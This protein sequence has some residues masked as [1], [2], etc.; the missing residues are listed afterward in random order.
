VNVTVEHLAPCRKL[1]R[2][3]VDAQE[4]NSAFEQSTKDFQREARLPGFRPGKAPREMVAKTYAKEIAEE[5][6]RKLISDSYRKALESEKLVVIGYPDIEE[7]QFARGQP[8]QFAATVETAPEFELPEYKGLPVQREAASVT[9]ADVERAFHVLREQR[10]TYADV[11]RPAQAQ[12]IVVVN[13]SGTSEG[14]PLTEISP[15]ARGLTQ[16]NGFWLQIKPD[17]FIPGF[18]EQLTGATAG[19]KRT[20]HVDF[21][22]D[23]VSPALSGRKGVYE[24]EILQVKEPVLPELNEEFAK[25]YGAESIEKLRE[26]VRQDLANELN[27]K[28]KR[29]FRNQLIRALLDRVN[30]ELPESMVQ[31]QTRTVVYDIVREN[32]QRGVS[33]EKI[34]EQKDQIYNVANSSAKE[35]VKI[36]F[37]LSKIAEKE[38]I[39]VSEQEII[40]R[41]LFLAEQN[42]IKPD[43]LV[44]QL[45]ERNGIAEIQEQILSSKVLDFLELNAQVHEIPPRQPAVS[46]PA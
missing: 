35:R 37:L 11:S 27:F 17:S 13:Y 34:E 40:Q 6:K 29:D 2:V 30:F 23:F 33:K 4:V 36:A 9:D 20:I 42:N 1:V 38:N 10:L 25:A 22:A 28:Q 21:P 19:E 41:I 3:E 44:K 18:T 24:V 26:G 43:K 8:L 45:R 32:Q 7:I 5:A 39:K 46:P 16:Q 14:R 15:T 31:Q 12:D